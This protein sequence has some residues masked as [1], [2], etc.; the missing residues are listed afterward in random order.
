MISG[1]GYGFPLSAVFHSYAKSYEFYATAINWAEEPIGTVVKYVN[2]KDSSSSYERN[3]ISEVSFDLKP[4][5]SICTIDLLTIQQTLSSNQNPFLDGTGPEKLFSDGSIDNMT[6]CL[7]RTDSNECSHLPWSCWE[8]ID[9]WQV[10]SILESSYL[11]N[12][13]FRVTERDRENQVM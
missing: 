7:N 6:L 2:S 5:A 9:F 8:K 13:E 10:H 12:V 3:R 4:A 1:L 11:C